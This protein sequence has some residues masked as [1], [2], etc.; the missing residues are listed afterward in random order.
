MGTN[1][2]KIIFIFTFMLLLSTRSFSQ[3]EYVSY[4]HAV[5]NFLERMD[6]RHLISD[7]NSIEKPKTRKQISNYLKQVIENKNLLNDVDINILE[8]YKKEFEFELSGTLNNSVSLIGN[9][10]YN[11]LSQKEKYLFSMVDP[12]KAALFINL[13]GQVNS[14]YE[15]DKSLQKNFNAAYIKYGG[16]IRGTVLNRFGFYMKGT[17]GKV[18]GDKTAAENL[19]DIKFSYKYNTDPLVH[20]A[21]DYVDNTEGYLTADFEL[22]R[23]KIGRDRK[24][25]GYGPVNYILSDN[26]P[27]FDYISFDLNIQ[28]LTF[29]YFHGKLLGNL[30]A[31]TD[32]VQGGI[33]TVKDKYI[34]YHRIG[35][36]I[37][38][39][40]SFGLGEMIIYGDRSIDFSYL[41]PFNY[42]KSVEHANQDRDNS[43]LFLDV[44]N[45][46]IKGLKLFGSILI[47]DLDFSKLGTSWYGNE[48]LY[49]FTL[50]SSNLYDIIPMEFYAQYLRCEPYVFTHRISNNNYANSGY[51]LSAPIQPNSDMFLLSAK[52]TPYYRLQITLDWNYSR[53]GA[54]EL[55]P[56][57]TIKKNVGGNMLVGH[58]EFDGMYVNFLEGD[59]EYYRSITFGAAFEPIKNYFFGGKLNYQ[60]N[61]LQNSVTQKLLTGYLVID[62]RI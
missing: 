53:H 27:Q 16:Q 40:I 24:Q 3:A 29:S 18:F 13:V 48:L 51:S 35:I 2:I 11:F 39:D 47:D 50:Y 59:K 30:S 6:S 4:D 31:R 15:N 44:M 45:N 17:N 21:T 20:S 33:R 49:N 57:G 41:N 19:N 62:L 32:S 36:N 42:Y 25:I 34:G 9:S 22:I 61:S 38:R 8:D 60:V 5:Y 55:N 46:S 56:N 26:A 23:F 52:Y 10:E 43:L 14:I 12:D 7:Y 37:S 54:N 58:R 28:P 1:K